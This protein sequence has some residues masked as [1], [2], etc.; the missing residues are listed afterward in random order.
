MIPEE[1]VLAR[2]PEIRDPRLDK[3]YLECTKIKMREVEQK[4]PAAF[5][6]LRDI[7]DLEGGITLDVAC[8]CGTYSHALAKKFPNINV[9][10]L[11]SYPEAISVAKQFYPNGETPN[12]RFEVGDVYDMSDYRKQAHLVTCLASLHHFDD[13]EGA[14]QQIHEV[15]KD[16]GLLY[17]TDL[18]RRHVLR[19]PGKIR[20]PSGVAVQEGEFFYHAL[21]RGKD[22][23]FV[24]FLLQNEILGNGDPNGEDAIENH[25]EVF[26]IMSYIAAYIP[27]E[28]EGA[29]RNTGY[30][31]IE[32]F[33]CNGGATFAGYARRG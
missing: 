7:F 17:F 32:I 28:I 33:P 16:G 5:E 12:L 14:L 22:E 24:R 21:S 23:H 30:K 9:I 25:L 1:G 18:D 3:L 13:L 15:S 20:L 8:G 4:A 2:I 19:F 10:G 6:I 11:D 31:G 29:L 26:S 27:S